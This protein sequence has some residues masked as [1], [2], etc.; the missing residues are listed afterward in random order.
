MSSGRIGPALSF[1]GCLLVACSLMGSPAPAAPPAPPDAMIAVEK[2]L[3][4]V[5]QALALAREQ[6][7]AETAQ[8]RLDELDSVT[9]ALQATARRVD[10]NRFSFFIFQWGTETTEATT[11]RITLTLSKPVPGEPSRKAQDQALG[12][13]Q[14]LASTLATAI[15]S[16][17]QAGSAA[18]GV[19]KGV[20]PTRVSCEV[21]FGVTRERGG[22][23]KATI[24]PVGIDVGGARS[25]QTVQTITVTFKH[26][27]PAATAHQTTR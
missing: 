13:T 25:L 19:I 24:N 15:V 2:L 22:G 1:V 26:A 3:E 4:E 16:A 9:L 21:S 6:V 14:D 17:W 12:P 27:Q 18:T 10:G 20:E 8:G 23:L 11:S 7:G 5:N